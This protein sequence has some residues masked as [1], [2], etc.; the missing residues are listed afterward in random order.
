MI[1]TN[2]KSN[3]NTHKEKTMQKFYAT[4]MQKQAFKKHYVEIEASDVSTARQF[5]ADHFGD[6]Y[7]F[8]Y[9]ERAFAGQPQQYGLICLCSVVATDFGSSVEYKIL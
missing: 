4:F 1:E 9:D 7:G 3:D 2:M 6:K 8:L 5:M